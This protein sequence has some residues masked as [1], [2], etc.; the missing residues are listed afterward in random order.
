LGF[1]DIFGP[2]AARF[3]ANL[4]SLALMTAAFCPAN[5]AAQTPRDVLGA[6]R[7]TEPTL[8]QVRR[9]VLRAHG[10]EDPDLDEWSSR[11]RWS[12]LLPD[13][14]GEVAWLDQRDIEARYSEDL[15]TTD[16]G[17]MFRDGAQNDFIDDSRL[18]TIYAVTVEWDLSGLIYDGSEPRI[19][20]EVSRRRQA[21]QEQLIE[22]GEAY[23]ARR[24]YQVQW[25]LTPADQW[26]KR[27][28]LRLE[29]NRYTARLD[30]MTAG[31]FS[32]EIA[33]MRRRR[34]SKRPQSKKA[35][36]ADTARNKTA[37]RGG[38]R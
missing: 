17:L 15:S 24:R 36:P 13:L 11:A 38:K 16:E 32:A 14:K 21:R 37:R 9:Q 7:A 1:I 23:Y 19:A 29:I 3:K 2:S 12:H 28:D 6:F 18:R 4:M 25:A 20:R 8:K 33:E 10:W 26:R 34:R 31:W 22:A 35:R 27:I 30:A 5:L